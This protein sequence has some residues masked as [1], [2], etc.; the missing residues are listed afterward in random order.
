[1]VGHR[2]GCDSYQEHREKLAAAG[3][4][5]PV[6]SEQEITKFHCPH[7]E[8]V[9]F[10]HTLADL[11]KHTQYCTLISKSEQ[12]A[13]EEIEWGLG[14]FSGELDILVAYEYWCRANGREP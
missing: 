6:S 4:P 14:D 5:E 3:R 13:Y 8:C 2:R 9:A 10:S 1:M 7:E 12:V 11:L